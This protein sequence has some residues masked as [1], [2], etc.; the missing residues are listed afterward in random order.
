MVWN[1]RV[2]VQFSKNA[3]YGSELFPPTDIA[4]EPSA[5]TYLHLLVASIM[6]YTAFFCFG[7]S[8]TYPTMEI[9]LYNLG[10]VT[11][12]F[13][14]IQSSTQSSRQGTSKNIFQ[15][16]NLA[17]NSTVTTNSFGTLMSVPIITWD[18]FLATLKFHIQ[19]QLIFLLCT[20]V[21]IS[22]LKCSRRCLEVTRGD[23]T[24]VQATTSTIFTLQENK[25][26][27]LALHLHTRTWVPEVIHSPA[28]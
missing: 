13:N 15:L 1:T 12:V 5:L 24:S 7:F 17:V 8:F 3:T 21:L 25:V 14:R 11:L 22:L 16:Y 10:S 20:W 19:K 23:H 4:L 27:V 28:L 18:P 6:L 26:T 9:S 2:A